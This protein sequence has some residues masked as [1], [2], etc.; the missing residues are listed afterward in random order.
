[1]SIATTEFP[2]VE[3]GVSGEATPEMAPLPP[4]GMAETG[5][6]TEQFEEDVPDALAGEG[7]A[8]PDEDPQV[9]ELRTQLEAELRPTLTAELTAKFERDIDSLRQTK[10]REVFEAK[11]VLAA[12]MAGETALY[13]E[14]GAM[15]QEYGI[16]PQA[17]TQRMELTKLRVNAREQQAFAQGQQEVA[18]QQQIADVVTQR[19][20]QRQED[21]KARGEIPLDPMDPTVSQ[22]RSWF[23]QVNQAHFSGAMRAQEAARR[24]L[25]IAPTDYHSEREWAKAI[26][27]MNNFE[28]QHRATLMARQKAQHDAKVAAGQ[29]AAQTRQQNR[30]AQHIASGSG[31]G[32]MTDQQLIATAWK[33][34]PGTSEADD[35][36]R[37]KFMRSMVPAAPTKRR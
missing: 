28:I 29:K 15:L 10:D 11:Q 37:H 18:S 24:G 25:P 16:D 26:D 30:G 1:M 7:E 31:A 27:Q 36:A 14:I 9:V 33:N 6:P 8:P 13:A 23:T 20:Q 17:L 22:W 3:Q 4:D 32:P 35:V 19:F 34:H 5:E 12:K 21:A 2:M